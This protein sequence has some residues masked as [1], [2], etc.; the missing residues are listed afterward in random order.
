MTDMPNGES[1]DAKSR[2]NTR[3]CSLPLPTYRHI[4]GQTPH[5]VRDSAGHSHGQ[6][7]E[8][9]QRLTEANWRNHATWL[10]AAD[11]FNHGYYWEA[12]EAWESL[13]H[14]AGRQ[15]PE[16]DLFKG[17]IKLAAA[18]VKH[19]ELRPAGVRRHA[20]RAPELLAPLVGKERFGLSVGNVH[21]AAAEIAAAGT[22]AGD[23]IP[24]V[25]VLNIT[26][27]NIT[28]A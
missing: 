19:Y 25:L 16:A 4:P 22:V 6:S 15:G 24:L 12:H 13:W 5:P 1:A 7:A 9:P 27:L 26:V 14:A 11:L 23:R 8:T 3:Y 28:D 17:L 18:G 21:G 20:V 2:L 10:Y